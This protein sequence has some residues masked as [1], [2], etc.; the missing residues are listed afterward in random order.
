M[1]SSKKLFDVDMVKAMEALKEILDSYQVLLN[2]LHVLHKTCII[3]KEAYPPFDERMR[4]STKFG[5]EF[6]D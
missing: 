5:P 1:E 2:L 4:W 3:S 6:R